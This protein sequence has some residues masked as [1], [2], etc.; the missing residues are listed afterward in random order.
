MHFGRRRVEKGGAGGGGD[1]VETLTF[2]LTI[3]APVPA[4]NVTGQ[5]SILNLEF[6][7]GF[8]SFCTY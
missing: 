4:V 8:G 1:N 5:D 2:F 3:A 7:F 6:G